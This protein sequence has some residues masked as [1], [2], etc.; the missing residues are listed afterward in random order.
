MIAGLKLLA[1]NLTGVFVV[2]EAAAML[3]RLVLRFILRRVLR[4]TQR[5]EKNAEVA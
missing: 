4:A 3:L 5:H 1:L 2:D